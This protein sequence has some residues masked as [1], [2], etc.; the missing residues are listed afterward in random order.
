LSVAIND[1]RL[2]KAS[3][4]KRLPVILL[5]GWGQSHRD[6]LPLAEL[7]ADERQ[8]F[9]LDLP[10]FGESPA[11]DTDWDTIQYAERIA[12]YIKQQQLSSAVLLGHSFGGRISL[13]LA[14]NSPEL[15]AGVVLIGSHGL[16][17]KRSLWEK[18]RI[19]SI[20]TLGKGAKLVDRIFH[21]DL[22]A[23]KF[24]PRFGSADYRNAGKLRGVLVKTVNEDQTNE[25]P[26]IKAPTLLL[27]GNKD[28]ETPLEMGQRMKGLIPNSKL[29][30]LSGKNHYPHHDIGSHLCAYYIRPFLSSLDVA[31]NAIKEA[32]ISA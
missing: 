16:R 13:R 19:K 30:V 32:K 28:Q 20:T 6:L 14:K 21:T 7:L 22:F 31:P 3:G 23:K 26:S 27:W 10:G 24:A 15:V 17:R 11:P 2:G 8:V 18:V 25:L 4:K 29:I 1:V 9:V 5:H 12:D